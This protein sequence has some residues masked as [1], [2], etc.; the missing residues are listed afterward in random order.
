MKEEVTYKLDRED[1][2]KVLTETIGREVEDKIFNRFYNV[3]VGVNTVAS[4]H[5]VAPETVRRYIH[6]GFINPEPKNAEKGKFLFRLSEVL[7]Y[8]FSELRK[9]LKNRRP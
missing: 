9:Q 6:D 7:R 1:F 8:D 2:K 5:S 3:F 4:I